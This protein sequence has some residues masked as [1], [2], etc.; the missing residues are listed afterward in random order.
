M[1]CPDCGSDRLVEIVYGLPGPELMEQMKRGLVALGG[2]DVGAPGEDPTHRCLECRRSYV[3]VSEDLFEVRRDDGFE[4]NGPEP[5]PPVQVGSRP[6]K[7]L[8]KY[9]LT[10]AEYDAMV[11]AQEGRCAICGTDKPGTLTGAWPVDHNHATK[12]V[13]ALLCS[14]CN[15]GLGL[16]ADDPGRLREAA[17][18]LETVVE[19]PRWQ[20]RPPVEMAQYLLDHIT[21]ADEVW[22]T[23]VRRPG[24]DRRTFIVRVLLGRTP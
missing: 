1:T 2:C 8:K 19:R 23:E 4:A 11:K 13:R 7:G 22:T 6:E 16:F 3:Q 15:A 17:T 14:D 24:E 18:Y 21:I 5:L 10:P 20:E 9:Q 12:R